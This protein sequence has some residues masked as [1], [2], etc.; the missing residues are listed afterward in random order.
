MSRMEPR[1]FGQIARSTGEA[2]AGSPSHKNKSDIKE[3]AQIALDSSTGAIQSEKNVEN[4][5]PQDTFPILQLML[6]IPTSIFPD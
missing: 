2:P 5:P 3:R 1:N 4:L 6:A